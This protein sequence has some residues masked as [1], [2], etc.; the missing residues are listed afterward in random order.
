L[1]LRGCHLVLTKPAPVAACDVKNV[2]ILLNYSVEFLSV[3]LGLLVL[4]L[5][6]DSTGL[7]AGA[8]HGKRL[9]L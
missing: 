3:L 4:L 2:L 6:F 8:A 5:V 9:V 7:V 1:E